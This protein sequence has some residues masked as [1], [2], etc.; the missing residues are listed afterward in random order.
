MGN[1][2]WT[3]DWRPIID[4]LYG[5]W[6]AV[7]LIGAVGVWKVMSM[8]DYL[9]AVPWALRA[10][11]VA[12]A[13]SAYAHHAGMNDGVWLV[14]TWLTVFLV[15]NSIRAHRDDEKSDL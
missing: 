2:F 3:T 9:P 8:E 4:F 6:P 1:D 14:L 11:A 7:V 13:V 5:P 12:T 10:V 15:V